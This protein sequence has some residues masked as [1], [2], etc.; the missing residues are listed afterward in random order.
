LHF[1]GLTT[2]QHFAKRKKYKEK[3][4]KLIEFI[5]NGHFGPYL[6]NKKPKNTYDPLLTLEN[7]LGAHAPIWHVSWCSFPTSCDVSFDFFLNWVL[8]P[9]KA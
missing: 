5:T 3:R 6:T 4:S 2:L 1:F 7:N 8:F 9:L